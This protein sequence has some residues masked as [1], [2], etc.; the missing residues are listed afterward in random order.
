MRYF[1]TGTDTNIGKTYVSLLLLKQWQQQGLSTLA[2]KPLASGC[3]LTDAGVRNADALQLQKA[4]SIH[5]PDAQV[6]PIALPLP[7]APHLA[8]QAE[9]LQL[10][11]KM[12]AQKCQAALATPADIYLI[13]GIGGWQVPI[14][15]TETMADVVKLLDCAVILVVG[16]RLGCLNHALLTYQAILQDHCHLAGWIANCIDSEMLF[17]E[18]NIETLQNKIAA[19]LLKIVSYSP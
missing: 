14:N 18:K 6:N 2:L 4:A 8:A 19:P 15:Q 1:I 5:L 7:I 11:A 17:V 16:M 12:I 3:E 10:T 9:N 13:E